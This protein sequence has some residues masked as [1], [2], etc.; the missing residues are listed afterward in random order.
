MRPWSPKWTRVA[1]FSACIAGVT[2]SAF[3]L[4]V[5]V[6]G[7]YERYRFVYTAPRWEAIRG[8]LGK[9]V[10]REAS[11]GQFQQDLW[12][13]HGVAPGKR[14]G[15]YVDVGSGD[16]VKISN[17]KLLDELGWKGV[18][19]DPFPKHM[20]TRTCQVFRQPVSGESGR[21]V[22]F[23]AAGDSGR[24]EE[25]PSTYW[26]KTS[27][28]PVIELVTATLDEIL[29]KAHAP[30]YIDY[31]NLDVEGAECDALRGLSL[32]VYQIGS[33]TVEHNYDLARR[34]AIHS[35]LSAKGYVR[36]RSW[37][38][39]DW[40]VHGNLASHYTDFIGFCGVLRIC[41]Y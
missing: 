25:P 30:H 7:T 37:E 17:T 31:M 29:A 36:V 28:P 16:G 32:D 21:R 33:L 40:Y 41:P 24:I 12:V 26:D 6:G 15:Y 27:G 34:A 35:L 4:G 3:S 19:I 39:D 8:A 14:D 18:C 10:G 38:V 2:L 1:I 22:K 5:W 11:Y 13:A 23:R 9:L 20:E